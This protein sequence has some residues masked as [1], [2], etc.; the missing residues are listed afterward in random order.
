M[1]RLAAWGRLAHALSVATTSA[2]AMQRIAL[3]FLLSLL[4]VGMQHESQRHA[5][6][7]LQP[8]LT[9]VHDVAV[10]APVDG[11][12]CVECALL[13]GGADTTPNGAG[14]IAPPAAAAG[15]PTFAFTSRAAA[16]PSWF[17]SRAPPVLL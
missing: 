7:H 2:A 11:A 15:R 5:L 12:A 16:A 8:L 6:E 10:H 13:A 4:L 14:A 1:K 17:D 3:T 9:R